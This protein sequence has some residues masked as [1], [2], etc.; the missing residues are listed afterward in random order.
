MK[1]DNCPNPAIY[2]VSHPAVNDTHYCSRCLPSYLKTQADRG[3][4][5][6]PAPKAP[7]EAP[8]SSKK[9]APVE[10]P[11]EMQGYNPGYI[12]IS[13]GMP[14]YLE[15]DRYEEDSHP[16]AQPEVVYDYEPEANEDGTGFAPGAT[17]QN[18]FK[19][20]KHYRCRY[21]NARVLEHELDAHECDEE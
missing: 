3:D 10:E 6:F 11:A 14:D 20:E 12:D 16:A 15:L 7:A 18:R 13:E 5:A 17:A 21:C 19:P 8:K 4:F 2:L 1:C 9:K